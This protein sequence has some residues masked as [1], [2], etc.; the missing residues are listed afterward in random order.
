MDVYQQFVDTVTNAVVMPRRVKVSSARAKYARIPRRSRR[1]FG[2][3]EANVP[4]EIAAAGSLAESGAAAAGVIAGSSLIP[5]VG[6]LVAAGAGIA[7]A[8]G[9]GQGCGNACINAADQ[10]QVYEAAADDL[11]AA[12][13]AGMIPGTIA[14]ELMQSLISMAQQAEA[15]QNT[16][17]SS[18]GASNA[19]SVIQKEA[20]AAQALGS[21]ISQPLNLSTVSQYF[22]QPGT[23]GWNAAS[24]SAGATLALQ[25]LES[26]ASAAPST[27]PSSQSAASST[28]SAGSQTAG[29]AGPQA[30]ATIPT[31]T[32]S[33]SIFGLSTTDIL[34]LGAGILALIMFM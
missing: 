16:Q 32:G 31:T 27:M 18:A 33:T 1:A 19:A 7:A 8:L 2:M 26:Y 20:Q 29:N 21:T 15:Q 3:G 23:S 11:M 14:A 13:K 5:V 4:G 17:Q 28:S 34:I 25:L 22:I 30:V 6:G 12:A 10:E 24:L 9:L